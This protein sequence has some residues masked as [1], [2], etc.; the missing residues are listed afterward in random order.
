MVSSHIWAIERDSIAWKDVTHDYEAMAAF[1]HSS[2]SF[3]ILLQFSN[4]GY[5]SYMMMMVT[6]LF[7]K[8]TCFAW[9]LESNIA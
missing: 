6:Q 4:K 3:L 9:M 7:Y 8:G 5:Y 2:N 1:L